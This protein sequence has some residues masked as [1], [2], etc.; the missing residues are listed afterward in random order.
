MY[1]QPGTPKSEVRVQRALELIERAQHDLEAA[2][3][4]LS[5]I[6]GGNAMWRRTG[7]LAT[8][9]HDLWRKVAYGNRS[10]WLLDSETPDGEVL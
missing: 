5:P 1:G 6:V 4:E 3:A 2:C 7:A 10:R 9:A 8:K